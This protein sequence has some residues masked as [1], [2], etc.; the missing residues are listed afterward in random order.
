MTPKNTENIVRERDLKHVTGGPFRIPFSYPFLMERFAA[1]PG[2]P[3]QQTSILKLPSSFN[4]EDNRYYQSSI[5]EV[6][7]NQ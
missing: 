2:N 4:S 3:T 6:K 1:W 7:L 5:N